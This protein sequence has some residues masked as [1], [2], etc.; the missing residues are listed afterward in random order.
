MIR[1]QTVEIRWMDAYIEVFATM[2]TRFTN[3]LIW[4]KLMDG[5][6]RYIPL[7]SVRWY[8]IKDIILS[9]TGDGENRKELRQEPVKK[10][11]TDEY[12]VIKNGSR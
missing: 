8:S 3:G 12:G 6:E 9:G 2:A 1:R 5:D 10:D 4:M 11:E 7:A